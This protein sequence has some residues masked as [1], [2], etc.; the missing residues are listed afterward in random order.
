MLIVQNPIFC[1]GWDEK[2]RCFV[3]SIRNGWD[4]FTATSTLGSGGGGHG[5]S[6][7]L[8][9]SPASQS[10]PNTRTLELGVRLRDTSP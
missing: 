6:R 9:Q 8:P 10:I 2:R 1:S 4:V 3:V 7:S 5:G